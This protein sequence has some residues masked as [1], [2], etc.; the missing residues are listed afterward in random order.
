MILVSKK[1]KEMSITDKFVVL[2]DNLIRDY[3]R[4]V[5]IF[6]NGSTDP[7]WSDGTNIDLVR[8]HI[9]HDKKTVEETFLDN[10][11]AY[12]DE[13]FYPDPEILPQDFMAVT[14]VAPIL[15]GSMSIEVD[16]VPEKRYNL[17]EICQVF[18]FKWREVMC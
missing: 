5:E 8:N 4:W 16:K 14:R 15:A 10:F 13:Y 6:F 7:T 11:L 12:P 3:S 18:L 1:K 9:R 2:R 17:N